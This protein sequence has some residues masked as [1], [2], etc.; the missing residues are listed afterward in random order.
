M[1]DKFNLPKIWIDPLKFKLSLVFPLLLQFGLPVPFYSF[2]RRD[3]QL[4]RHKQLET[5]CH[6]LA[7][8]SASDCLQTS[9]LQASAS[10]LFS[11]ISFCFAYECSQ[12]QPCF[13]SL[14]CQ[15]WREIPDNINIYHQAVAQSA[16]RFCPAM[17]IF[18]QGRRN[19]KR[20]G[21]ANSD[22]GHLAILSFLGIQIAKKRTN[23]R[24]TVQHVSHIY[25]FDAIKNPRCNSRAVSRT[26]LYLVLL[27][28]SCIISEF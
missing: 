12:Q 24:H 14:I 11:K 18:R 8:N 21:G 2:N 15:V 16:C 7:A 28:I 22:K 3:R 20:A 17:L 6:A 5:Q 13:R 10:N 27:L 25:M 19:D 4:Y 23:L 1:L 9:T 26:L